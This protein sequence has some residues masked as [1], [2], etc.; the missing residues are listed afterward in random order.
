MRAGYAHRSTTLCS[1][2]GETCDAEQFV[3]LYLKTRYR[4]VIMDIGQIFLTILITIIGLVIE[5]TVFAKYSPKDPW[6]YIQVIPSTPPVNFNSPSQQRGIKCARCAT[7]NN[8]ENSFCANCGT[9]LYEDCPR[10]F[11]RK[12]KIET[13]CTKCGKNASELRQM[14]KYIQTLY[15]KVVTIG[16][17]TLMVAL[18]TFTIT[19][20][21][22]WMNILSFLVVIP[23]FVGLGWESLKDMIW[24]HRSGL[25]K[26]RHEWTESTTNKIGQSQNILLGIAILSST[27]TAY[28]IPLLLNWLKRGTNLLW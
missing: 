23:S 28:L 11:F 22:R 5:Y 21:L 8:P 1:P 26:H 12:P 13:Y 17:V 19:S 4:G 16:S 25:W 27:Q 15:R 18:R 20:T 2:V 10:C 7:T 6:P 9:E 3:G 14:N 24:L